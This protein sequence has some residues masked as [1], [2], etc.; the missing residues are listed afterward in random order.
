LLNHIRR[1][2]VYVREHE[3]EFTNL[4]MRQ[5]KRESEKTIRNYNDEITHAQKRLKELDVII[6]HL[7]EDNVAGKISD[8]LFEK[9]TISYEN[10]QEKL[11]TRTDELRI[12]SS[13]VIEKTSN[14]SY[15][16]SLAQKYIDIPELNAKIIREFI[17]KIIVSKAEIVDG[18]RKQQVRIIYNGVGEVLLPGQSQILRSKE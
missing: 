16:V 9:M 14:V 13:E 3:D 1:L 8:E 10:E 11:K 4:V 7:Y 18:V 6:Q 17:S 12:A 2:T 5:S 15:M